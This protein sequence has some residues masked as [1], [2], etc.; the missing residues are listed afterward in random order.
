MGCSE[1][2]WFPLQAWGILRWTLRCCTSSNIEIKLGIS[3]MCFRIVMG[4]IANVSIS[5]WTPC[6]RKPK[7]FNS[8][9]ELIASLIQW[10][11]SWNLHPWA[12]LKASEFCPKIRRS[13]LRTARLLRIFRMIHMSMW[14]GEWDTSCLLEGKVFRWTTVPVLEEFFV[15]M[16]LVGIFSQG[17]FHWFFL[18]LRSIYIYIV[19]L[20]DPVFA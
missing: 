20:V 5:K 11:F 10:I 16:T 14:L 9:W 7:T 8:D 19:D 3:K 2:S 17:R 13:A 15:P 1:T 6:S 18:S 12:F 4:L